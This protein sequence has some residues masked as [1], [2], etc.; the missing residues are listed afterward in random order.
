MTHTTTCK[1]IARY[2]GGA[3]RHCRRAVELNLRDGPTAGVAA[4]SAKARAELDRVIWL[5]SY[6]S[7]EGDDQC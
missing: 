3:L 6:A 2:L 7:S 1:S 5:V 4:A